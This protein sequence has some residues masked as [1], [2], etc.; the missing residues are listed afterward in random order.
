M[1]HLLLERFRDLTRSFAC[2]NAA[3][4]GFPAQDLAVETVEMF[5]NMIFLV[6]SVCF[7]PTYSRDLSVFLAGCILF[8][9]GA[10]LYLFAC[11]FCMVESYLHYKGFCSEVLENGLYI[12]G[13]WIFLIGTILYWPRAAHYPVIQSI[14]GITLGQYFN[15]YTPEFEGTVLFALGS[16]IFGFAAF[17]NAL[18][19]RNFMGEQA[20]LMTAITSINMSADMLFIAGSVAFLPN[21]G[22]GPGMVTLGAWLFI[23]ASGFFVLASFLSVYRT[24]RTWRQS[25]TNTKEIKF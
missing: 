20:K 17:T 6:G 18:N 1:P 2:S 7:L 11:S 4:N 19:H 5:A 8:V 24:W 3:P 16:A 22:C 12:F 13:A 25:K 21:M 10:A 23:V 9:I 15:L 14:Q